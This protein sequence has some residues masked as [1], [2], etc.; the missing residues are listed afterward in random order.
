MHH[1]A[2]IG[3]TVGGI[4]LFSDVTVVIGKGR[5]PR[6]IPDGHRTGRAL[7][8]LSGPGRATPAGDGY[9]RSRLGQMAR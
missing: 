8:P 3:L 7:I 4:D 2:V 1:A 6:G 5:G 9:R